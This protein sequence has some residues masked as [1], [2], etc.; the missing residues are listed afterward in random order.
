MAKFS[1]GIQAEDVAEHFKRTS[2]SVV[3]TPFLGAGVLQAL[4]AYVLAMR[5]EYIV[6]I[7]P[8]C[9]A[10]GFQPAMPGLQTPEDRRLR[11]GVRNITG[12]AGGRTF[13]AAAMGHRAEGLQPRRAI[14]WEF[15]AA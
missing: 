2:E 8:D 7:Y 14:A 9:V 15:S 4:L 1:V 6:R 13:R 3:R 12:T 10:R 5:A 11:S